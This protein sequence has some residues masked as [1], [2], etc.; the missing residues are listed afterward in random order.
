MDAEAA[1]FV[2]H[3]ALKKDEPSVCAPLPLLWQPLLCPMSS[4]TYD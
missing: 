2:E 4:T 3:L 1:P